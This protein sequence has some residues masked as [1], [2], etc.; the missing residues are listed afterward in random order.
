[1]IPKDFWRTAGPSLCALTATALASSAFAGVDVLMDPDPTGLS[2]HEVSLSLNPVT[3]G[4]ILTAYNDGTG[5]LS[6]PGLGVSIS[7]DFGATWSA[8]Q[9]PIPAGLVDAFDPITGADTNGTLYAGFISTANAIGGASGL[10]LHRSLDGGNT[11][12]GPVQIAFNP[13]QAFPGDPSY[14]FN[15]KPHL[16]VDRWAASSFTNNVYVAWIQDVG[17][18]QPFSD[19]LFA[20]SPAGG[21]AFSAPRKISDAP[22]GQGMNNGPS[23]AVAPNG[24]IYVAWASYDV[25]NAAQQTGMLLIDKSSDGGLTWS[26]DVA[27]TT[28]RTLP[29]T[30]TTSGNA[31]HHINTRA[32]PAIATSPTNSQEVYMV[33]P[34]DPDGPGPDEGDIFFIKSTDG[35]Q[36]WSTPLRVNDDATTHDQ[37]APSIAV[38]PDGTIDIAWYDARNDPQDAGW[39]VMIAKS[40]DGG[41]T[42]S[43]NVTI[44]DSTFATPVV[45]GGGP[46]LGEY[47]GLAVDSSTAYLG[48]ASSVS[49]TRG[50]VYFDSILNSNIPEPAT[51]LLVVAGLMALRRG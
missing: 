36:T 23:V 26:S 16:A 25:T 17:A 4:N 15:D 27:V 20:A 9:L 33:Y 37:F 47:L 48:F 41:A 44:S 39:D 13:A 21:T 6:P 12:L 1:M 18:N 19:I 40:T 42:F 2:Q 14:R 11:W 5:A 29:S 28:Y 38:K 45:L 35:G 22:S 34:A 46:R 10:Y 3:S 31:S 8:T 7:N 32:F 30:L 24:T 49:D 51:L 43:A 50:D